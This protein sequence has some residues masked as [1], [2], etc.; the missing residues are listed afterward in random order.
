[1]QRRTLITLIASL[2]LIV[3]AISLF[4]VF[5][6]DDAP[7]A[8]DTSNETSSISPFPFGGLVDRLMGRD[9]DDEEGRTFNISPGS[10]PVQIVIA[11]QAGFML[12]N[13]GNLRYIERE[14]GRVYEQGLDGKT[15][16]LTNTTIARVRQALWQ[17]SGEALIAQ[18]QENGSAQIKTIRA[19]LLENESDDQTP[20][21]QG[22]PYTLEGQTLPETIS[23][24]S[25][26]PN[27]ERFAALH[28]N[29][30]GSRVTTQDFESNTA[31]EVFRSPHTS[32]LMDWP[33]DDDITL[34]AKPAQDIVSPGYLVNTQNASFERFGE[35]EA[36]TALV[37]PD[38]SSAIITHYDTDGAPITQLE[39][40]TSRTT[41]TLPF[42]T[43][44]AEKC[45]YVNTTEA[46]CGAPSDNTLV[47]YPEDWYQGEL[48]HTDNLWYI[49]TIAKS[50]RVIYDTSDDTLN[51][52]IINPQKHP[53]QR[54]LYFENKADHSIWSLPI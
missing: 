47:N 19:S 48:L 13:T 27:G 28:T 2:V 22:S 9:P 8:G 18:Y 42:T 32:W 29:A 46:Y 41:I 6:G 21:N 38:G 16:R 49:D 31:S 5:S 11:P 35:G 53:T 23:D 1:M 52:D 17:P 44:P 30:A 10:D 54:A 4:F 37:S 34:V 24:L 20:G 3:L 43:Y 26:S 45:V 14:T 12:T 51:L 50:A 39:D 15:T 36:L 25:L 33:L 7:E 40:Y